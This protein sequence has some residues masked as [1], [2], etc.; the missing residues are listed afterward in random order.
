MSIFRRCSKRSIF[1]Y[2]KKNII[3]IQRLE[4]WPLYKV[5]L[6][7]FKKAQ[8]Y[9]KYA[10]VWIEWR[11]C[12]YYGNHGW[13]K[14][15]Q[16]TKNNNYFFFIAYKLFLRIGKVWTMCKG[17]VFNSSMWTRIDMCTFRGGDIWCIENGTICGRGSC[18]DFVK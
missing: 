17:E 18:W 6:S 4:N 5:F 1:K 7:I 9:V 16:L 8:K 15:S 3:K 14:G 12:H 13:V 10:Y 2:L 11:V